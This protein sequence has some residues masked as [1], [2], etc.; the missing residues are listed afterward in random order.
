MRLRYGINKYTDPKTH[1]VREISIYPR[2]E[3]HV[4]WEWFFLTIT[5]VLFRFYAKAYI[6]FEN[7][8][9]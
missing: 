4:R 5:I 7:N 6:G 9:R 3:Y 8:L 1:V 2:I